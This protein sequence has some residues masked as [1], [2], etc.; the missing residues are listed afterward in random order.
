MVV[1][2]FF[3]V[4]LGSL[5]QRLVGGVLGLHA[6]LLQIFFKLRDD[7]ARPLLHFRGNLGRF[8]AQF[9]QRF[10]NGLSRSLLHLLAH[11]RLNLGSLFRGAANLLAESILNLGGLLLG[12]CQLRDSVLHLF[13]LGRE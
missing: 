2:A 13:E 9:F 1:C 3:L 6:L 7:V 4:P 12:V 5:E 8:L 11:I 10:L